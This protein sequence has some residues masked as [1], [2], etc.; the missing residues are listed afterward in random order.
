M[1]RAISC[2]ARVRVICSCCWLSVVSGWVCVSAS[3]SETALLP[4]LSSFWK[5]SR[6]SLRR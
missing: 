3:V 5:T 4:D 2:C 6:R 1:R